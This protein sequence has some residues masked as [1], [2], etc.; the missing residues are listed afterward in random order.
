MAART[1]SACGASGPTMSIVFAQVRDASLAIFIS[2]KSRMAEPICMANEPL[3]SSAR[4]YAQ[5]D[6]GLDPRGWSSFGGSIPVAP[7]TLA[8]VTH[9]LATSAHRRPPPN[10]ARASN[11]SPRANNDNETRPTNCLLCLSVSPSL[12]LDKLIKPLSRGR[13]PPGQQQSTARAHQAATMAAR[14]GRRPQIQ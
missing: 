10:S 8:L 5:S 14:A 9:R 7:P 6:T 12:F 11:C 3:I 1:G 13:A 4:S 2:T